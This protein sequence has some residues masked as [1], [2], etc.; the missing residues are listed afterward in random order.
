[1][2]NKELVRA[3]ALVFLEEYAHTLEMEA[4]REINPERKQGLTAK[5]TEVRSVSQSINMYL[6]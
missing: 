3:Q 2:N 1:M 6:Q 4:K 5:T